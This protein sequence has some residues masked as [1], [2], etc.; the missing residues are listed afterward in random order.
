[1]RADE[2]KNPT[3]DQSDVEPA[4]KV[5]ATTGN[6]EDQA[7]EAGGFEDSED[8]RQGVV[9]KIGDLGNTVF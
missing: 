8:F 7:D 6:E 9:L 2:T 5:R 1:M 3:D 4:V